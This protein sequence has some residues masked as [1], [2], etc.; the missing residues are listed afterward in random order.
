MIFNKDDSIFPDSRSFRKVEHLTYLNRPPALFDDE[1][2]EALNQ[3]RLLCTAC[4]HP[5][6]GVAE[7]TEIFGRHDHAFRYYNEVVQLG[8][9]RNADGC[10]GVD[11]ISHGYSWF[12]G[13]AWQIQLCKNCSTQLGWKYMTDDDSFYGLVFDSLSEETEEERQARSGKG[14]TAGSQENDSE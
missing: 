13:Y 3:T 5:A 9:Y 12:R 11:R 1:E 10:I 14:G 2:D 8:C 6:T 7:K 4:G